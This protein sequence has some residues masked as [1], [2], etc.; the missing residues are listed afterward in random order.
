M[1]PNHIFR[2]VYIVIFLF[3]ITFCVSAQKRVYLKDRIHDLNREKPERVIPG[4]SMTSAPP[5]DAI[6]LFD[7][8]NLDAWDSK[9]FTLTDRKTMVAGKGG[10]RSKESFGDMQMHIEWKVNDSLMP[11]GQKGA[12]SGIF[13]MGRYEVQVLESFVNETYADGQAG[14]VYG[15]YPPLVNASRPQGNW[16][17]Y[18]IIFKAPVY[19]NGR[20][21]EKAILTLLHNGVVVQNNQV[22]EG[23]TKHKV[24]TSYPEIHPEEAPIFIQFHGDPIEFRNIWVRTL[25][26]KKQSEVVNWVNP[27]VKEGLGI[28]YVFSHEN[29]V[30]GKKHFEVKDHSIEVLYDWVGNEAPFAMITT[31]KQYSYYNLE[32]EYKWGERKFAPRL[33]AK[34]DA[35]ILFHIK[36]GIK[37]WP[38]SLECQVQEH[39][40]GDLWV[41]KGP[42][43]TV[44]E[45]DGNEKVLDSKVKPFSDNRKYTDYEV[46]GWNAVRVE[47]RGAESARFYVNGHLVNEIKDFTS[48]DGTPLDKGSIS[49][50][51]EGAELTYRNVRIQELRN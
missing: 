51:A 25:D 21:K 48:A 22:Y 44:I 24:V 47:V 34:R 49:L 50:Q 45:K 13:I 23:A 6:I 27:F 10:L 9:N 31:K 5:S 39:D 18:D 4:E 40:T 29:T 19:E 35:G 43:V 15:Q 17:S 46:E 36:E 1:K 38:T 33:E 26:E 16:N 37:P 8:S 14:A 41:I 30:L 42:K 7:G 20:V 11:N 32:L 12:N 3:G 2:Q 28:D